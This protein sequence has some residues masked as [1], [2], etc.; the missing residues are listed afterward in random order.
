MEINTQNLI[1]QLLE[2][3]VHFGHQ[4]SK[5]NPKMKD[6]IFAEKS[7]IYIIDLQQTVGAITKACDFIREVA[8][9]GEKILFVGT[10][11]QARDIVKEAAEKS[12][13]FYVSE[14]WLGGLLTNFETIRKSVTRYDKIE[15][16]K[17][18]GSLAKL[19]KKEASQLNKEL[20]RL[21]KNL[22]GVREMK[23]YPGAM[24]IID[25]QREAIAVKEAV[26]LKLP[27]VALVDT[28]CDP[29]LINYVIPGNDDAI[30]SIRL[31]TAF[32]MDAAIKG[33]SE[34]VAGV[35]EAVRAEASEKIAEGVPQAEAVLPGDE[36]AADA[37]T[38]ESRFRRG[39]KVEKLEE[40]KTIKRKPPI[41]PQR[42]TKGE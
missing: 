21:K 17:E 38:I 26:K 34:F 28:N 5:W 7:G 33:R 8:K 42:R 6:Y 10:K 13:M 30:R 2:A 18:D 37:E 12:G 11:K 24:F 22:S 9:K 32:I 23:K 36:L 19:S 27:V 25:P 39:K 31:I 4:K 41:K 3:G 1:K 29:A 16:M 40:E 35:E 20:V 15:T 14:R